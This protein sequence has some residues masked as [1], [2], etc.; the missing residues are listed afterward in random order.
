MAK[1]FTQK[2]GI[3]YNEIFSPVVKHTSIR[4]LLAIVACLNLELKQMDVKTAFLHR[5]LEETIYMNQP[6]G[7]ESKSKLDL[8]CKPNRSLYGLKQSPRCWYKR[9]DDFITSIDFTRSKF[10]PC[11]YIKQV[12]ENERIYLLLYVDD[13]LIAGNN[14]D[15]LKEIKYLLNSEFE[16]KDLG[17]AKR[18]LGMKIY[19][20]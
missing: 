12:N 19:R 3:N 13:M 4:V 15:N 9:F 5:N 2:E 11:V 7:F 18:I 20:N 10:H 1:G 8:V 14:L 16:M 6:E 17:A